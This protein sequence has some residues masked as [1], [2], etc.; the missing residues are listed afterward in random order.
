[1]SSRR[2]WPPDI[3]LGCRSH[4]PVE[5]ELA[6]Q[7]L[8]ALGGV[9]RAHAV[10]AGV[11]DDLLAGARLGRGRAALRHVADAAADADRVGDQVAAGHRGGARRRLEQRGQHAQRRRLAGAVGA[12]EADDLPGGDVE[13]DARR[14]RAPPAC[15]CGR[16]GR[17]RGRGSPR[18]H[19]QG[20][21]RVEQIADGSRGRTRIRGSVRRPLHRVRAARAGRPPT[22]AGQSAGPGPAPRGAAATSA[23]STGTSEHRPLQRR[24]CPP[25]AGRPAGRRR[26]RPP[27]TGRAGG[28]PAGRA[29]PRLRRPAARRPR[30]AA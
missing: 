22:G 14:R 29:A 2:R 17:A 9:G 19:P 15:A 20:T 27:S 13:V 23:Q 10:Q 26:A 3:V 21:D 7:L 8:A 5:V 24:G 4:R 12:E 16:C 1:M 11:V 25:T 18:Q 30:P 6:E 28:P